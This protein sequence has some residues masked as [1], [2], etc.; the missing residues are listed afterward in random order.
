MEIKHHT[1]LAVIAI[2]AFSSAPAWAD[3]NTPVVQQ[4]NG[5]SYVSGGVGD[6]ETAALEATK[7]NYDLRIMNADKTGHFNGNS[8]IVIRDAKNA[9]LVDAASGPLFYAN[10]P[11]GHYVVEGSHLDESKKQTVTIS[12]N[13]PV[14]I[15]FI[16]QHHAAEVTN[17][18]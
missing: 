10:L 1:L 5:I 6:E 14:R 7:Q 13:K 15:R 4:Q 2:T 12:S 16:W 18:K 8:H 3:D 9:V 17:N 11:D